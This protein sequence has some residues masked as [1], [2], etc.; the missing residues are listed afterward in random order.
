MRDKNK[1]M[2]NGEDQ[3]ISGEPF[4]APDKKVLFVF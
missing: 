2:K 1:G 3:S 4:E